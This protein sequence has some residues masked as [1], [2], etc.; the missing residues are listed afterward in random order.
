MCQPGIALDEEVAGKIENK[1][2]IRCCKLEKLTILVF[3]DRARRQQIDIIK[4]MFNPT[5]LSTSHKVALVA[6]AALDSSTSKNTYSHSQAWVT[7][8][9]LVFDGTG[10]AADA[11]RAGSVSGQIDAFLKS[12]VLMNG[13]IHEPN[14][15]RLQWGDGPLQNFD[16]RLESADITYSLFN[17][18][19]APIR[20]TIKCSF[21]EDHDDPKRLRIEGK[22]SPDLTHV[23]LV[24]AGDTLPILCKQIYGSSHYYLRVAQANELDDFRNIAPGTVI[25]FP[26]L[27]K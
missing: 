7:T 1:M 11:P 21:K 12:T 3:K 2:A 9:D 6:E 26:P 23:R 22:Q 4:A 16:C 25:R 10:V 20:A 18:S 13:A 17:Q 19:G 14:Y 15:L 8:F 24:R 27:A 5:T